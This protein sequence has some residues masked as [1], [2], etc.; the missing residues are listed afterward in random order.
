MGEWF[1][2]QCI[3]NRYRDIVLS[4]KLRF[5]LAAAAAEYLFIDSTAAAASGLA[6]PT[7]AA[8]RSLRS[9]LAAAVSGAC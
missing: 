6:R 8:R 9:L 7:S 1:S 4:R 3:T 2:E 5:M